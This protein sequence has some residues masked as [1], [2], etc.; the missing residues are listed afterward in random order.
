MYKSK[1]I[2]KLLGAAIMLTSMVFAGANL[3]AAGDFKPIKF[4]KET[5]PNGLKVIYH[6]DKSAPIVTTV[7]HY[8]VGSC[9]ED[10]SRTGYAHFFEHLMF[11]ATDA[12]PRATIDKNVQ[13]AGGELNAY[14]SFD[15]TVFHF[16]LPSNEVKL[17]LWMESQRMRKLHVDEIGVE[18]QRGVVTEEL[19][20]RTLNQPYGTLLSKFC[21][22]TFAGSGYAWPVIGSIDHIAKATIQNF[23]DFYDNY[24]QPSNATLVIAGD[25]DVAEIKK[26]VRD[27]FG[28]YPKPA[29]VKRHDE[30]KLEPLKPHRETVIDDK[31]P[32]TAMFIGYRGP[33][34]TDPDYY[35]V[36]LLGDILSSG[37]SSRLYQRLVDKDQIAV[38]A[39]VSPFAVRGAGAFLAQIVLASGKTTDEAEKVLNEEIARLLKDGVTDKELTKVKNMCE[40][41]FVFGKKDLMSKAQDLARYEVFFGDAG[42]INTELDKYMAVTKADILRVAKKYLGTDNKVVLIYE[43]KNS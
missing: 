16:T 31:A 26:Y 17:A 43:P 24:Y 7:V 10:T 12:I 29:S 1:L 41:Q 9:D 20:M 38:E 34:M 32:M 39:G 3:S 33:S 40:S 4:E 36:S 11:E 27:Y 42:M 14:T 30:Y 19:K 23:K 25:I 18:T 2:H 8:N 22:N 21:A 35:A 6:V 5:L 13:E 37:E 28:D 15:Q